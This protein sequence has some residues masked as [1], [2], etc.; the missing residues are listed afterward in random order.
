VF[1]HGFPH[2]WYVW[3]HQLPVVAQLGYRAVAPDMRG[4]GR[5]DVPTG[6]AS[7]T[8]EKAALDLI[9]LLDDM[10]ERDAVFVGLDFGAALVWELCLR[11]P[12]R[13]RAAVVF[14][15]P[16]VGRGKRRPSELWARIAEKHFLHLHYFQ[17]PGPAD[18]E[19]NERPRQFLSSIYY[20]LSGDY[21]Y[22]DIW[23][24]P[25]T[26]NG[27]LDV[28]PKAPPLPWRWM[29]EKE[30]DVFAEEFGRT[31]FTGGLNW[32]RALDLNWELTEP[33][34]DAN[35]EVPVYFVYGERDCDME[36]FSGSDPIGM[37][38]SRV[39]GLREV[40]MV[41]EAG[42][43]VQMEKPD[44]VNRLLTLYLGSI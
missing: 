39:P 28:L 5:S 38:K 13:V 33:F 22:L 42:H 36:G 14:N 7:Y 43:L 20:A 23:S 44:D 25:T 1:C 32:Y 10:G 11:H 2:V 4:Y 17:E 18:S 26:G 37:M 21:H 8:N 19:L 12:D 31:G 24:N 27:Y 3:H 6:V 41:P 40:A 16:F 15:N 30:F 34:N 35:I 29:A 9:G